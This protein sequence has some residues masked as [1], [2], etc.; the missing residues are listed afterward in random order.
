[1]PLKDMNGQTWAHEDSVR[2]GHKLT[3]DG[4]FT[5]IAEHQTCTVKAEPCLIGFA[6]LYF[7]CANGQHFLDGQVG[8]DGELVGLYPV[9]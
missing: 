1:M 5:C 9:H 6:S 7:D 8:E 2:E 3:T 4:G